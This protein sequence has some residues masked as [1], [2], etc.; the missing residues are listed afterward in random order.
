MNDY[1][2]MSIKY[3]QLNKRRSLVTVLGVAIAVAVLY[4][5]LNMG[6]CR[7]LQQRRQLR[8]EMDYEI[9]FLTETEEQIR[10]ITADQRVKS[11]SVG[12]YFYWDYDEPKTPVATAH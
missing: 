10:G 6:L 12:E 5:I 7:L 9:V 4:A 3:L 11:S 2:Q 8:E 1:R